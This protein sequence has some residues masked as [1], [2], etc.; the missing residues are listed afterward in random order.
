MLAE[1]Q[2]ADQCSSR[3]RATAQAGLL[4]KQGYCSSRATA[5]AGLLLKQVLRNKRALTMAV[6]KEETPCRQ[7]SNI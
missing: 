1:L 2:A 7:G 5:Q 4:L 3:S 6:G